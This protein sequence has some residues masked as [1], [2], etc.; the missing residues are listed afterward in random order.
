MWADDPD[1]TTARQDCYSSI[2][3]PI[4]LRCSRTLRDRVRLHG[5]K[6]G[7]SGEYIAHSASEH[8]QLLDFLSKRDEPGA[9]ALMQRHLE[10]SRRVWSEESD[11]VQA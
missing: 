11:E 6:G 8:F 3:P 9:V 1:M 5:F 7:K 2:A 10:R 4:S